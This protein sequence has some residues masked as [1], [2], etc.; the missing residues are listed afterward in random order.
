MTGQSI[1]GLLDGMLIGWLTN[2]VGLCE[3]VQSIKREVG[4]TISNTSNR[5]DA[6]SFS[7]WN[8]PRIFLQ[9]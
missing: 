4:I 2:I 3:L 1:K 7:A 6:A 9:S 8:R 5:I